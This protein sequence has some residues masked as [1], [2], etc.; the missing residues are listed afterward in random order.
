MGLIVGGA[1]EVIVEV[2]EAGPAVAGAAGAGDAAEVG[3]FLHGAVG[4]DGGE[5]FGFGEALVFVKDHGSVEGD[6]VADVELGSK[7]GDVGAEVPHGGVEGNAL[8][9]GLLGGDAVD[10][11]NGIGDG[12][13]IGINEVMANGDLF[14][15]GVVKG[16]ADG[17]D[18]V[19]GF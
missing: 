12:E 19:F 8:G 9:A 18:A 10:G 17:D 1:E 4:G 7:I 16:P 2:A 14:G 13:A 15:A 6:V 3:A 11:D 5:V